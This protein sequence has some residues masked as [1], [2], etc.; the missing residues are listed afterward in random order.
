MKRKIPLERQAKSELVFYI[1]DNDYFDYRGPWT[2]I[3]YSIVIVPGCNEPVE[4]H[5]YDYV[6]KRY[7]SPII[8]ISFEWCKKHRPEFLKEYI[9][10]RLNGTLPYSPTAADVFRENAAKSNWAKAAIEGMKIFSKAAK[11]T[12]ASMVQMES[13]MKQIGKVI[14]R[15]EQ[16][17]I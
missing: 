17:N 7:H 11:Q 15:A 2:I 1:I 16:P 3:P 4:K 6:K 5:Y 9:K 13:A 12:G 8:Y 10:R 14:D